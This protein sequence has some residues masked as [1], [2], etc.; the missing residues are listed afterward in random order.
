M[1]S[2]QPDE[3][4][5]PSVILVVLSPQVS[6]LPSTGPALDLFSLLVNRQKRVFPLKK[7]MKRMRKKQ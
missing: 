6:Q 2:S 3:G 1:H 7:A 5:S 4:T